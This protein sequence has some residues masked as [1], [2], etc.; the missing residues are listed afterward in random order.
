MTTPPL[1]SSVGV[2]PADRGGFRDPVFL[3]APV[4]SY[5]TVSLAL[6]AGHPEL[7]GLPETLLFGGETVGSLYETPA[8]WAA[9]GR[10]VRSR[11]IGLVR[12][13]AQLHEA[14]Q[15]A[16]ALER[17]R[18]WMREHA[19]LPSSA[20]MDH[21]LRLVYPRI[22]V[23]K[24]PTT[25]W[26]VAA[27]TRCLRAYPNARYLHLTRHPVTTQR[28]M[29]ELWR[30][31]LPPQMPHDGRVRSCL[32]S[33]Y[34]S[35][36][37][38]VQALRHLP[39]KQWMR[40]RAEDLLGQPRVWLPRIL[41][42]L[43][44]DHDETIIGQMMDTQRWEFAAWDGDAGFGGADHKFLM[45]PR[46]RPVPPPDPNVIDPEWKISD[47]FRVRISTLARYLGYGRGD[48]LTRHRARWPPC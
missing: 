36:L 48:W 41:D 43:G 31:A 7:Y 32:L 19:D 6:L 11:Q 39:E 23:E 46:L 2:G 38:V 5:S 12:A 35:H 16:A 28:S 45:S 37:R 42:W 18:Q 17:A 10:V 26:S 22:G 3:L 1:A 44:L 9:D 34:S 21:L 29:L 27:L 14:S 33:W 8:G 30:E 47:E 4:R 13:L 24:S 15:D 20:M 25:T 40:V